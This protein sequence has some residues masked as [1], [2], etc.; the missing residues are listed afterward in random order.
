MRSR[1]FTL[2]ELLVALGLLGILAASIHGS[3]LTNH[4]AYELQSR[5]IEVNQSIRAA[6]SIL[7][8]EFR[9]LD[10]SAGDIAG[11]HSDS[12]SIRAMRQLG[13]LCA[14]PTLGHPGTPGPVIVTTTL[15][16]APAPA[17]ELREFDA[18]HDSVLVHYE[19]D[20]ATRAD[21][22]WVAGNIV[23]IASG[24]C[25]E[26]GAQP[27]GRALHV[28][29]RFGTGQWNRE[30]ALASGAP[31]RG[32]ERVTYLLYKGSDGR[33]Y[34]G[35]R[36]AGDLQP[37]LGPVQPRGFELA[38]YDAAGI[39]THDR[40]RVAEIEVRVRARAAVPVP[41]PAGLRIMPRDSVVLRVAL[42][43]NPWW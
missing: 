25:A 2:V 27:A 40:L 8:G 26:P 43:G 42:R 23:G 11:L 29:L 39:A 20:A 31:I 21:D 22:G 6:E 35:Q 10:A 37:M 30:H 13:F 32:F 19:G 1:G 15:V 3:L 36:R 41:G 33:S 28:R 38:Y 4:R 9:E 18:A 12:I 34:V 14:R 17:F 24:K 7:P 16:L 5:R